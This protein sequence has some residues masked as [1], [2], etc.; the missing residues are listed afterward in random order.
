MSLDGWKDIELDVLRILKPQLRKGALVFTDNMET[1]AA[2][3][4][5]HR[6][7]MADPA[8]GFRAFTLPIKD[9]MEMAV[10]LGHD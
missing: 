10:Y 2:D 8:N 4:E 7:Y 5:P 1:F 3:E 6:A 9:G